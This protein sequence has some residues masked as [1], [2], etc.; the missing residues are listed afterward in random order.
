M[1]YHLPILLN[2][3][4]NAVFNCPTPTNSPLKKLF[5]SLKDQKFIIIVPSTETLLQYQDLESGLPLTELCYTYNFVASH[6]LLLQQEFKI[7]DQE[8]KTLNG[9]TIVIK[10]QSGI[11]TSKPELKR[12]RLKSC[13]ILRNFNDYLTSGMYFP[14]LHVDKPLIGDLVLNDELQVFGS[15][16]YSA[17]TNEQEPARN[18][19]PFEQFLSLYPELVNKLNGLINAGKELIRQENGGIPKVVLLVRELVSKVYG[20]TNEHKHFNEYKDLFNATR[21]YVETNTFQD[22]W[23][24]LVEING[25]REPHNVNGYEITKFISLNNVPTHIYPEESNKFDLRNVSE[26]EQRTIKA[27]ECFSKMSDTNSHS[28]KVKIL[29]STFQILTTEVDG[30][31]DLTLDA[32]TLLGLM[33]VVVCRSQVKNLKSHL[34][35]LKEFAARQE[36]VKF[37]LIGY[38]LSTFEAVLAFFDM[39]EGT[40]Q[41]NKI[42]SLSQSNKDFW[43]SIREGKKISLMQFENSL[44]SRTVNCESVFSLCIQAERTDIMNEIFLKFK[45]HF[46]FEDILH[47]VN[48]ANSTLLIQA[49]ETGND[50]LVESFVDLLITN[51]TRKEYF[52]YLNKSNN[53]GRTVAH[54]LPQAFIIIDKVGDYLNWRHKDKNMHSPLFTICR[55]YDHPQYLKMLSKTFHYVFKYYSR[56]GQEFCFRDHEDP[57]GNT[58]LHI[59]K[60][61]THLVLSEPNANVNQCNLKGMTPLMVYAK[62]NRV[63]NIREILK[64]KRLLISKLQ[65]PQSLRAIDYVKNPVILNML[66]TYI[67]KRSIFSILAVHNMKFEENTWYVWITVK[68]TGESYKTLRHSVKSI[69]CFLQVFSKKHPMNFLP[70]EQTLHMLKSIG[71]TGILSVVNLEYSTFLGLLTLVLSVI[72]QRN[73]YMDVLKYQ[74]AELSSWLRASNP[75][76]KSGKDERFEPEEVNSMKSFLTF[77]LLE[78][79]GLREKFTIM[80]KLLMFERLKTQDVENAQEILCSQGDVLAGANPAKASQYCFSA[81]CNY[82]IDSYQQAI[83]FMGM[84][85]DTLTTKIQHILDTRIAAW[86]KLYGEHSMLQREYQRTTPNELNNISGSEAKGIFESYMEGKRQKQGDKLHSRLEECTQSLQDINWELKHDHEALAEEIS[87]FLSFKN[88]SYENF[89]V[90]AYVELCIKRHTSMLQTIGPK[91]NS[92]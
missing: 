2:P 16:V 14:L 62:Y 42:I 52:E 19:F 66:G 6:L 21:E 91:Y 57:M 50:E 43:D 13:Q 38:S 63:D 55:A 15:P 75:R 77:N 31:M 53:A 39:D 44:T 83:D 90:K 70:I 81:D 67:A 58:L 71:R 1:P 3:L 86:W 65:N 78:F 45:H 33:V 23:L 74:E 28:G 17:Y 59:M 26:I 30:A 25:S 11:V 46:K 20:I 37:G 68:Q 49:L 60:K 27:T 85:L 29:V 54:Y 61:G 18:S 80:R 69:Q 64:D 4:L 12:C 56:R 87:L 5:N 10:P 79:N 7:S 35:Y 9:K 24:K 40:K 34:E 89:I 88:F 47:D 73:E 8:C 72:V 51:C 76:P 22:I 84:C 48:Y 92:I 36:D 82:D 41:L 32:D